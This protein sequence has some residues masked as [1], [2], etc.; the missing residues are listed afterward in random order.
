MMSSPAVRVSDLCHSY[1]DGDNVQPVIGN[2][3][4]QV[5]PGECVALLG[6]SGSGKSTLLNLIGGIDRPDSGHVSVHGQ[7][8]STLTE[9]A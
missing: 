7:D 3:T 2:T 5:M 6:R 8:I 4:M 9:P 1:R